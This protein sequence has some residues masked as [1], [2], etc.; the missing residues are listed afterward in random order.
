MHRLRSLNFEIEILQLTG[1]LSVV[2]KTVY[3]NW[4]DEVA[5]IEFYALTHVGLFNPLQ[6]NVPLMDKFLTTNLMVSSLPILTCKWH[7]TWYSPT[8]INYTST[9]MVIGFSIPVNVFGVENVQSQ[10]F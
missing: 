4:L 2:Y 10:S 9:I 7:K 1:M 3:Y 5:L 6:H 8:L